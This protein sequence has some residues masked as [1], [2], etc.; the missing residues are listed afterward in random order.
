[1]H[2]K[3][4]NYWQRAYYVYTKSLWQY[5]F[6]H[7]NNSIRCEYTVVLA[8]GGERDDMTISSLYSLGEGWHDYITLQLPW[9]Q[10]QV[11]YILCISSGSVPRVN[12]AARGW[13][14]PSSP[15]VRLHWATYYR[16]TQSSRVNALSVLSLLLSWT[17]T[18][19]TV[20]MTTALNGA[21]MTKSATYYVLSIWSTSCYISLLLQ[22]V[23]GQPYKT[24]HKFTCEAQA[25]KF[26]ELLQ[27]MAARPQDYVSLGGRMT[28]NTVEGF[29]HWCIERTDLGHAHYTCKTNM[30]ICHKVRCFDINS[31]W[32]ALC[33]YTYIIR[34]S[35]HYGSC[36]AVQRWAFVSSQKYLGWTGGVGEEEKE[37][38]RAVV[39]A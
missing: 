13:T 20:W 21:I 6:Y 2:A 15:V 18:V 9:K 38:L 11:G 19:T 5:Y 32:T 26:H 31:T 10:G 35:V 25:K 16:Q 34:I 37:A 8:R 33:V 23:N 17:S 29:R 4:K 14:T 22:E 30:A 24:K 1:M 36:C 3:V 12:L 39:L 7:C 27:E 28:T